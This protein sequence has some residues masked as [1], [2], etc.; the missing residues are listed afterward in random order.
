[1]RIQARDRP[2]AAAP[3]AP[4]APAAAFVADVLDEPLV[5]ARFEQAAPLDVMEANRQQQRVANL[6][7]MAAVQRLAAPP[8]VG[9]AA[10]AVAPPSRGRRQRQ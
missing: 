8:V 5:Q 2:A 10:A 4:P 6:L 7:D 1:M 3:A 9:A